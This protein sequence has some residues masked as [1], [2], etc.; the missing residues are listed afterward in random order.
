[1]RPLGPAEAPIFESIITAFAPG[2]S[3][4]I[5]CYVHSNVMHVTAQLTWSARINDL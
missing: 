5:R 3:A 2:A 1:M 4:K